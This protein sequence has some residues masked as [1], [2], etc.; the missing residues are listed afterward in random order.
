MTWTVQ[1]GFNRWLT[2]WRGSGNVS[3]AAA[4][5]S[6]GPPFCPCCSNIGTWNCHQNLLKEERSVK[7]SVWRVG[8]D[9][10]IERG[11]SI[12]LRLMATKWGE[13]KQFALLEGWPHLFEEVNNFSANIAQILRNRDGKLSP[14]K[15]DRIRKLMK[16]SM[17]LNRGEPPSLW[18]TDM[19]K[20]GWIVFF[21]IDNVSAFSGLNRKRPWGAP[22][23][24]PYGYYTTSVNTW[25]P[26]PQITTVAE[27]HLNSR[28]PT[29][30][31]VRSWRRTWFAREFFPLRVTPVGQEPPKTR[32]SD[33]NAR[34]MKRDPGCSHKP[35]SSSTTTFAP[36]VWMIKP[37]L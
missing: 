36:W 21:L 31:T 16:F 8:A 35:V 17:I 10:S 27:D 3:V 33:R 23:G 24:T 11:P 22:C 9:G 18:L 14:E 12:D 28:P 26:G 13:C 34:Q 2:S 6:A 37:G 15:R 32:L 19:I 29:I 30:N 4:E 7:Y 20:S 1:P 5:A 25:G